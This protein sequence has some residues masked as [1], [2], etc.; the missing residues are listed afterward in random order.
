MGKRVFTTQTYFLKWIVKL[1]FNALEF[2]NCLHL[3][4]YYRKKP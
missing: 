3:P 1:M 2:S 4:N